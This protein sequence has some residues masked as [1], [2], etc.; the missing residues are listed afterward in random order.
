MSEMANLSVDLEIHMDGVL[1]VSHSMR[2]IIKYGCIACI[3]IG[4]SRD[5]GH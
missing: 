5:V 1:G 2:S 4:A 3:L